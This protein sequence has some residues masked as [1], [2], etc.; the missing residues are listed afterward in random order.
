MT[1]SGGVV[2][3]SEYMVVFDMVCTVASR[4]FSLWHRL[5]MSK[6]DIHITKPRFLL[7]A[8]AGCAGYQ[9][10]LLLFELRVVWIYVKPI[11][12]AQ[13]ILEMLEM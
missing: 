9:L 1:L 13:R 10:I 11:S 4:K 8:Q 2:Y 12:I 7:S 6:Y 5:C 3:R